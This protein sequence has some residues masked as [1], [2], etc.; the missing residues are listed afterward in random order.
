MAFAMAP[1]AS[2]NRR[3]NPLTDAARLTERLRRVS[4]GRLGIELTIDD[5]QAYTKPFT[6]KLNQVLAVDTELLDC[7]D[8]EK[9]AIHAVRK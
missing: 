3:G 5:S 7:Q 8:N 4:Y 9:D 6:L 2:W 1:S